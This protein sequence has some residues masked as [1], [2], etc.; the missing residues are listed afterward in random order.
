MQKQF[1]KN[2][3]LQK[4]AQ[5][6]KQMHNLKNANNTTINLSLYANID[7][8]KYI[9]IDSKLTRKIKGNSSLLYA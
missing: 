8:M 9:C 1:L 5:N 7:L 3:I 2:E 6:V 4:Y